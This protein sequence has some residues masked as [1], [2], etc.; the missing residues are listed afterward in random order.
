MGLTGLSVPFVMP[1]S[2]QTISVHE[3]SE[4]DDHAHHAPARHTGRRT[5]RIG[6]SSR[7]SGMAT[8]RQSRS[9]ALATIRT[10]H[11]SRKDV[12]GGYESL[13]VHTHHIVQGTQLVLGHKQLEQ[14]VPGTNPLRTLAQMPGVQFQ[15]DDP[16]GVDT[17]STQLYMHGFV[18]NEIGMTLDGLPIGE[19]T[20]RNYNGLNP[21]Q[22]IS[23]ENV[24]RLEVTQSAGAES[25]AST[26]NLGGS[27]NYV[28]SNPKNKMGGL[29][30]QTFGSN[31]LFHSFFRFDSGR[32]NESGTKFY[33]SYMRNQGDKWK[34]GGDQFMQQV[35]AS[36]SSPSGSGARF[37]PSS[38]GTPSRW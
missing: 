3:S 8:V 17:Y 15:S 25:T 32:L 20:F 22:A 11:H 31:A 29:V 12:L 16:Q 19:P 18:Q 37:P 10:K 13:S 6:S 14:Q 21:L 38:T 5:G 4:T 23:S 28:S 27:I 1:A 33:V 24:E 7:H 26:N 36:W 35:N 2:A 9:P 34:G 30:A